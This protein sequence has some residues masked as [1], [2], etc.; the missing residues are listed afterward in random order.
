V[1]VCKKEV[2][3]LL[4]KIN[5]LRKFISNLAGRIEPL[6]PQIRLKHEGEFSWGREQQEAFDRI[7]GYLASALV[8]RVPRVGEAFKVYVTA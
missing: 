3:S 4:G 7:K 5:Y 2:Q 6:L 1:P 8:L